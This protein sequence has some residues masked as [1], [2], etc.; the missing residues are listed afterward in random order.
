MTMR[1]TVLAAGLA[2]CL[3]ALPLAAQPPW[4]D[5]HSKRGDFSSEE[6]QERHMKRMARHL[7]LSDTQKAQLDTLQEQHRAE[8]EPLHEAMTAARDAL[9]A[10]AE[11]E[12]YDADAIASLAD[13]LG[14]AVA[15]MAVAKTSHLNELRGILSAEQLEKMQQHREKRKQRRYHRKPEE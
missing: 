13:D 5:G 3:L 14:D 10:Q 4:L 6:F 15:Q 11:A 8:M 7:D 2:S 9:K 12:V 1:S